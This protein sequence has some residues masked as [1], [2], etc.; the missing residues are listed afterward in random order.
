ME[1]KVVKKIHKNPFSGIKLPP[2]TK[3]KKS[4]VRTIL[5]VDPQYFSLVEGRPIKTNTSI[6][7]YKQN[8]R[9]IA[10][11]RTLHGFLTDEILRINR[12][13][14]TERK[15]YNTASKH[16][17][18]YQ[19][20][21]DKFLAD[22]NNK[23]I[24]IMKT[25]DN[26]AKELS[27]ETEEHKKAN[28][29]LATIKSKLQYINETLQILL[30]FQC[31]LHKAAPILWQEKYNINLNL[32]HLEI[33]SMDSDIFVE[34]HIN[35][36][37]ERLS[38]L[39][40]S[41]LYFKT[42]DQLLIV[43]DLLEKQNLNYLLVTEELNVEKNKFLKSLGFLKNLLGNELEFIKA[44]MKKI[45]ELIV[46][47]K[48]REIELK[49]IF[50]Q[51]LEDKMQYLVSSETVLQIF[52]YVEF[53]YEQVIASNDANLSS[54]DMTVALEEEYNNLML[55][56]SAF[57]LD[58]IKAIEKETYQN[59]AKETKQ[60]KIASKLLKDVNKLNKRLKSSYE[61]SRKKAYE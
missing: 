19:H 11:K 2:I 15:I 59:E 29:E 38:K 52:N 42:P 33:L 50:F 6:N 32:E 49:E 3:C 44:K 35:L 12:E 17:E 1:K 27:N 10:L 21:F 43:F 36:I 61:P 26:L 60:A 14:E 57:D 28:F 23:T 9:N 46:W 37:R 31:F 58:V 51:I 48:H 25:S 20:S 56:L 54:L 8:I 13:I 34:I 7:K 5:D 45:E 22:D 4:D 30:S 47:N 53:A 24:V 18:E 41:R 55:D 39:P 16:F 40:P